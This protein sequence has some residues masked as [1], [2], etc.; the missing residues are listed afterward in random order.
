VLDEI[1]ERPLEFVVGSECQ[2][3]VDGGIT[4]VPV[5]RGA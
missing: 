4:V 1:I 5:P 3:H 2:S